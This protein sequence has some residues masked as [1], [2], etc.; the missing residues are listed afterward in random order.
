MEQEG[1]DCSLLRPFRKFSKNGVA[2]QKT[3]NAGLGLK[4]QDLSPASLE[5]D[6]NEAIKYD[7]SSRCCR[8]PRER[9]SEGDVS[10]EKVLMCFCEDLTVLSTAQILGLPRKAVNTTCKEMGEFKVDESTVGAYRVRSKRRCGIAGK[11]LSSN[12]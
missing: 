8:D 12:N 3:L 10:H 2:S 6:T 9:N 1:A 7:H 4:T 5:R 11:C